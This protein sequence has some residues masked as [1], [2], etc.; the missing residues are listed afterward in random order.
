MKRTSFGFRQNGKAQKRLLLAPI[1]RI[2][3]RV[4]QP[5]LQFNQCPK[6]LARIKSD[7]F[8]DVEVFENV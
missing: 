4:A 5:L 1:G 8:R 2:S 7:S 3:Q 6:R